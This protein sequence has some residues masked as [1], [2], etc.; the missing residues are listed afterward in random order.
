MIVLLVGERSI[1][2]DKN[3]L[4]GSCD[5]S[6]NVVVPEEANDVEVMKQVIDELPTE[7]SYP[8]KHDR[9]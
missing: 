9:R 7:R 1:P 3:L 5:D 2:V 6:G 4:D 8:I